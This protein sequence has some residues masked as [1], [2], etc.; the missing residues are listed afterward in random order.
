MALV[1]TASLLLVTACGSTTTASSGDIAPLESI[2]VTP[3]SDDASDPTV[4]FDTPLVAT[5]T[6]AK[7]L[8]EGKGDQIKE[9]QNIK[10]KSI[11]YKATDASLLGSGFAGEPVTLPT[12]EEFKAQLPALYDTLMQTKV[13]SWI[14]MVEP[15]AEAAAT[16]GASPSASPEAAPAETVVV[17]KVVSTEEIPP[18][19]PPSKK[20]GADEVKKLKDA[21][22]LPTF[23]M[24][25]GKPAIT[26]PKDKDAPAGL[27]VDIVK[28]GTGK[29]ATATSKV[30]ANYTGVRWED[31]KQFDSSYDRGKAADF[32]LDGVIAGWTQGLTGLKAGT[33]VMLT[34][35]TDLAYGPDAASQGAP[36]GPLVFFVEL[37]EVK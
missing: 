30:S 37:K 28:E 19:A 22:A 31:G 5:A 32:G 2:K 36:E 21:G 18:A 16:D 8:V 7:V 15:A 11:A 13:G 3:G 17:L 20:L 27:V 25:D 35:P 12:N 34:I 9:N 10:F 4:T 1:A 24:K 6:A 33:Q 29:V 14:A 23:E 26:I